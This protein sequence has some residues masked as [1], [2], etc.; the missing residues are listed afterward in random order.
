MIPAL[1]ILGKEDFVVSNDRLPIGTIPI[2]AASSPD[3]QSSVSKMVTSANEV[4]SNFL[5]SDEGMGFCGHVC[6]IGDSMGAILAYDALS[7][8]IK[9]SSS[10]GSV[11]DDLNRRP[12][13]HNGDSMPSS[14]KIITAVDHEGKKTG[15]ITPVPLSLIKVKICS[16]MHF[17]SIVGGHHHPLLKQTSLLSTHSV[18]R[19][20][21]SQD[22]LHGPRF[23]FDVSD[24][25]AFGS[26]LGLL[27]AY[28]KV[29]VHRQ[30]LGL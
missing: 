14:P 20:Q 8:D 2:F 28:R 18:K 9:R 6:L 23:D 15:K 4:F 5:Q 25:F 16:M 7:R 13:P 11:N 19:D 27:L 26:P 17:D 10:E 22:Y 1:N 3:Y 24:F 30:I 29:Q 12:S 21:L